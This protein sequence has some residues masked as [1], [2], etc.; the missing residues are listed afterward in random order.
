M[1][2]RARYVN[3]LLFLQIVCSTLATVLVYIEVVALMGQGWRALLV[4]T[5]VM[6]VVAYVVLGVAPRTL[7][8]QWAEPILMVAAGP[9]RGLGYGRIAVGTE[10]RQLL[11]PYNESTVFTP[12]M[13]RPELQDAD[14]FADSVRTIS[15][16]RACARCST[17][18]RATCRWASSSTTSASRSTAR[19]SP[20]S[21]DCARS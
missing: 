2:D 15:T 5:A 20:S 13:L 10:E 11:P 9:T 7:G 17:A 3:V 21:A 18:S 16:K 12:E 1:E 6:V 19:R 14:I 8:R 4:A